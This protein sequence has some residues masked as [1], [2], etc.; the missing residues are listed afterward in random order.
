MAVVVVN[1]VAAVVVNTVAVAV[2][3]VNTVA[4]I[5]VVNTVEHG[6]VHVGLFFFLCKNRNG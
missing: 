1:T 2:V 3:A 4:A 5:V 6:H